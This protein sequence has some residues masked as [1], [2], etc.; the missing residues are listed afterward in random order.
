M[1]L[2]PTSNR[3]MASIDKLALAPVVGF[4]SAVVGYY[5]GTRQAAPNA[6]ESAETPLNHS[7][8]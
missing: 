1:M 2:T 6:S 8:E 3:H 4:A 5:Y 7:D